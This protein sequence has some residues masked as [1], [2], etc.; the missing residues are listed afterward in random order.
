MPSTSNGSLERRD[1]ALGDARPRSA[2]HGAGGQDGEL[3]AA[4][5]GEQVVAAE[6]GAQRAATSPSRRSP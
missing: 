4:E 3:V 5:A 6:R 1:E 2:S